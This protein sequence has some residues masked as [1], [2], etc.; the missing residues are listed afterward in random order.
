[1]GIKVITAPVGEP[2]GRQDCQRHLRL[3]GAWDSPW[4]DHVE[5]EL[6]EALLGAARE[7][8]EAFTGLSLAPQTLELALDEFPASEVELPRGPVQSITSVTYID[9]D[10]AAQ[11][12]SSANWVLDD[13]NGTAWLLPADGFD[14]PATDGVVNAVKIRYVAGFSLPNDSPQVHRLPKSIRSALLLFLG[15]LYENRETSTVGVS[16]QEIPLGAMALLR[17]HR[18]STGIA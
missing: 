18:V 14:W 5:G 2:I 6:I 8:A 1:M 12:I 3:D 13:Y 9:E 7:H 15:H 16:V 11:T 17:P 10:G 4:V